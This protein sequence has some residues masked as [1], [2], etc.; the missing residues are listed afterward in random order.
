M[1]RRDAACESTG[2]GASAQYG[3]ATPVA[4]FAGYHGVRCGI[5][6][7]STAHGDMPADVILL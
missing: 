5:Q 2:S 1:P 4:D 6:P 7:V 3:L